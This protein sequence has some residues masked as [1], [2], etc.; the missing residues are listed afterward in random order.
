MPARAFLATIP[1]IRSGIGPFLW[2][3]TS[4]GNN[5]GGYV[6]T[7]SPGHPIHDLRFHQVLSSADN[8]A[9]IAWIPTVD[10]ISLATPG[11]N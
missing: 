6:F 7:G 8:V 2:N 4:F 11:S 9:G 5:Q 3:T 10:R 1:R